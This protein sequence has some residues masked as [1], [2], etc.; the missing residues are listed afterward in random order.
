MAM[1]SE[2]TK[3]NEKVQEGYIPVTGGQVWYKIIGV[4]NS[5]IPLLVVHGGPGASHTYL[6]PLEKLATKR[7]II[8]Y[9]QLGCG[10]SDRPDDTSLWT[11][12]RF[13]EELHQ[14][15]NYLS[16]D[17]LHILGQSWGSSLA[18]EYMLTKQPEGVKSLVLS[19][20]LLSTSRWIEDQRAYIEQLSEQAKNAILHCEQ[21]GEYESQKYQDA[22]MEFYQKHVCR[23]QEWPE[24]LNRAF[25]EINLSQYQYMWGPSEFTVTGI[26]KSYERIDR[27]DEIK[28]PV[29]F[30]CGEFDEATPRTTSYYQKNLPG[31]KLHIFPDASHEHHIEKSEEYIAV[32][33]DFLDSVEK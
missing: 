1:D 18:V 21:T 16:L 26:L 27:L 20:A 10:N 15:R 30:T 25:T 33:H 32:V 22:M 23:L 28:I 3:A 17:S 7:P 12:E 13:T 29:L 4:H 19:G 6:Q 31:A 14:V 5:G 24:Y 11:L 2:I 8:F 9:D